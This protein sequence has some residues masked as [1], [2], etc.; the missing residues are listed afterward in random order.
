[1]PEYLFLVTLNKTS[2]TQNPGR[3]ALRCGRYVAEIRKGV[4]LY[5]ADAMGYGV[6]V[7]IAYNKNGKRQTV[8]FP[9]FGRYPNADAAQGVYQGLTIEFEHDGGWVEVY[10]PNPSVLYHDKCTGHCDIA[11]WDG[12]D[13]AIP[14]NKKGFEKIKGYSPGSERSILMLTSNPDG[15][16]YKNQIEGK[17]SWQPDLI[18]LEKHNAL[19]ISPEGLSLLPAVRDNECI[20]SYLNAGGRVYLAGASPYYLGFINFLPQ[21]VPEY[22]GV[23]EYNTVGTVPGDLIVSGNQ[24]LLRFSQSIAVPFLSA[25]DKEEQIAWLR[26]NIDGEIKQSWCAMKR[27]TVGQGKIVWSSYFL[28]DYDN[29]EKWNDF[30]LQQIDWLVR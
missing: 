4:F 18:G 27:K 16:P 9:D 12:K 30:I 25:N 7:E 15:M 28:L 20:Q 29:A 14:I 23:E 22:L 2:F 6:D 1:M 26:Q 10:N 11:I 24:N 3:I 17:L 13:F 19:I 8:R 21:P 5:A